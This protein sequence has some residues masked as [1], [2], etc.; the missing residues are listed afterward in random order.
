MSLQ[1]VLLPV[2]VQVALTFVLLIWLAQART[3][4]LAKGDVKAHDIALG[5][6][7]WPEATLKLGNAFQNQLELPVLFYV[8]V[9]LAIIAHKA[10][11]LFVILSWV[12]VAARLAHV[13]IHTGSNVVKVRGPL[14]GVGMVILI[15]MWLIFAVRVLA[16]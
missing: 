4:A 11:L 16:G 14:Y 7:A 6:K 3:R 1:A 13:F 10:D 2:F 5:Q 9:I 8:L 12:F 15:A